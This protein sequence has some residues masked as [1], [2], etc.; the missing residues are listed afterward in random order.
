MH[1]RGNVPG[2]E[3]PPADERRIRRKE[4]EKSYYMPV[5]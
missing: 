5:A 2:A 3:T 1:R 4:N